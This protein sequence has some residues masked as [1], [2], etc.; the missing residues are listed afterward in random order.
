MKYI[1]AEKLIAEIKKR[2]KFHDDAMK[3]C[4]G[5]NTIIITHSAGWKED[6][7]LLDIIDS[8][9]QE[10]DIIIINKKDWE[11]QEQFRKNKDFGKP[12]KEK[13]PEV[14][15]EEE[16][17]TWIPAHVRGGDNEVWKDTKN[18]VIEWGGVVA[19][20]FYELGKNTRKA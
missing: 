18:A 9:Q 11:A 16:I 5:I 10:K 7:E 20:H 12:L 14:D 19:R 4:T 6:T 1:D 2:I 3:A 8:L 15:L 17:S 13:Q